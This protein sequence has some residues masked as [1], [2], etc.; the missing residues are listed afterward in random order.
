MK[1]VAVLMSTYNGSEYIQEQIESILK[2]EKVDVQLI[3]R[4]DGSNDDTLKIISA[5]K[6]TGKIRIIEGS[7]KGPV[8]SFMELIGEA[9][10]SAEYY[11]F[12]DQDDI[13]LPD[14]LFRAVRMIGQTGKS[15]VLYASNQTVADQNGNALN[16]RYQTDPPV[17]LLNIIDSNWL[18]GCTM[19]FDRNLLHVL[20]KHQP[21][22][23]FVQ[24]R[25][26]DTWVAAVA[27]C[28]GTIV[29]DDESKMLYRQ[30]SNNVVGS[31]K[32]NLIKRAFARIKMKK[33]VQG[34]EYHLRFAN[35][36]DRVFPESIKK[37]ARY[38]IKLYQKTKSFRGKI[39]FLMSHYFQKYYYRN[40]VTFAVKLLF[41]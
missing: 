1:K 4:D 13:W 24:T 37:E 31:K 35:E 26:H 10:L 39:S 11:A 17:D 22:S 16:K 41:G 12:A 2:Q 38:V 7:N 28:I 15:C 29:Y 14:K 36:L 21:D 18:A 9:D 33:D 3:V 23:N 19:V 25:M 40:K 8:L 27:A 32:E 30:H 6:D 5:Y 20:Q 34:E